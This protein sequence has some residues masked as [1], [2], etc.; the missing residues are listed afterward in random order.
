MKKILVR[1]DDLG[2]SR[3]VNYGIHDAVYN[4]FINNVGI[5]VNMPITEA[6]FNMIK[7]E[8]IDFGQ[9]TD[10]TNGKPVLPAD[11]V[12]SL[13]DENG[14][15]LRSKVYRDNIKAGKPDF[16]N[17]EEVVA[18]IEAQYHRFLELIGRKPDYFEGHAVASPNFVKGLRIMA[19]KYDLPFLDFTFDGKPLKFKKQ[20]TF[21]SPFDFMDSDYD[22]KRTLRRLMN[23]ASDSW[24]NIPMM[25]CHP[26]FL[27][28]YIFETSS[29]TTPRTLEADMAIDQALMAEIKANKIQLIRYS[30]CE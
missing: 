30:E 25:V 21:I 26:G 11:Q 7:D 1:A 19:E 28:K 29:L 20:T 6:G 14:Y 2:Y 16:I 22:P 24:T 23:E 4:G 17:L 18:E 10:I 13:V 12:P 9:H 15:F 3:G 5:M 27:D 8:P